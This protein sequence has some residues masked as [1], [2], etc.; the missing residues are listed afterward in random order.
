MQIETASMIASKPLT[1][2]PQI[3]ATSADATIP[4][5]MM[6][7]ASCFTEAKSDADFLRGFVFSPKL[8]NSKSNVNIDY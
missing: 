7:E 5:Y 8:Y 1:N 3:P 2:I 4:T 6:F